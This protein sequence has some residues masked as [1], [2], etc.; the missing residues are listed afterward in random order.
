[1]GPK[2]CSLGSDG[3][4]LREGGLHPNGILESKAPILR[5]GIGSILQSKKR[6]G[7]SRYSLLL[8]C[9]WGQFRGESRLM[10]AHLTSHFGKG[11]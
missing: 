6:Q 3:L 9:G 8:G 2:E 1:M 11:F 4:C 10:G 7:T 5:C